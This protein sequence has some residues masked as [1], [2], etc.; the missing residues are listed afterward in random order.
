ML[1]SYQ[2]KN[3]EKKVKTTSIRLC[4]QAK[5]EKNYK[6]VWIAPIYVIVVLIMLLYRQYFEIWANP[7]KDYIKKI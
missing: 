2:I 7:F 5:R 1:L 3:V 6:S 4:I